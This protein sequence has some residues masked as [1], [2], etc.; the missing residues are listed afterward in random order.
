MAEEN[1]SEKLVMIPFAAYEIQSE[2]HLEEKRELLDRHEREIARM[3]KHYEK[4]VLAISI[5]LITFIVGIF[6]TI[7]Y[8]LANYDVYNLHQDITTGDNGTAAIEDGIHYN[9]D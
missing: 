7:L 5:L 2:Q 6:S 8:F 9:T 4:I 3:R 1:K